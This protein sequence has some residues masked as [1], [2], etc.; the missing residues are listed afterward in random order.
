MN[1]IMQQDYDPKHAA[2]LTTLYNIQCNDFIKGENGGFWS[3]QVTHQ[4]LNQCISPPEART[5]RGIPAKRTTITM[6]KAWKG[7]A[8][9]ES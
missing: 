4:T 2:T 6:V 7:I 8:I 3:G 5:E 1:F 9:E